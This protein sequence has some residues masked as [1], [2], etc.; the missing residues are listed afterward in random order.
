MAMAIAK[1]GLFGLKDKD[2]VL[3]LMAVAAAEGRHPATV[4]KDY[5]IIEG[6]P[7][8]K[9]DAMLARFQMAGGSVQWK[10]YSDEEV[11]GIF[12]H[13]Q[14]GALEVTWTL[15]M[16]KSIGLATGRDGSLKTNWRMYSRAMLRARVVSEGIRAVYPA[17]LVGEYTPEEVQDFE[18]TPQ[19][20]K[21]TFTDLRNLPER[22]LEVE[23][24]PIG[25]EAD[26][27]VVWPIYT[28][29]P[30]G[31]DPKI[32]AHFTDRE[33][34]KTVYLNIV[35]SINASKK[36]NAAQ[37]EEKRLAFIAVNAMVRSEIDALDKKELEEHEQV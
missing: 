18:T 17:V 4:A 6:R 37:K 13:P 8:L 29:G 20:A 5:H 26:G 22:P 36:L 34:Y 3:A 11:T 28:P 15:K 31:S 14:G 1:S 21:P 19:L 9:A 25:D 24:E 30:E 16:A 23:F 2:Q 7:A 10:T 27:L 32:Y 12:S 35:D 33:E